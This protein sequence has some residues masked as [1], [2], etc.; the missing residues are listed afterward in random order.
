MK[1]ENYNKH[2]EHAVAVLKDD[3]VPLPLTLKEFDNI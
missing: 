2:S 1:V 3:N